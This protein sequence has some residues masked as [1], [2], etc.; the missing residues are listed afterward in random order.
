MSAGDDRVRVERDGAIATIVLNRPEKLNALTRDMWGMLGTAV[1]A[2]SADEAV[3]CIIV[4]GA[5]ERAFSPGNDIAEFATQRANKS[6]A[7]EY[8]EV[9]HRTADSLARCRH[10][11]V[12]QI[13]G[14]CVG[15]GLEIAASAGRRA[16]S[17]RRSRT[18]AW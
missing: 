10:P 3:R 9:M 8:G 11:V 17:A 15:G 13:H 7:I 5:G 12:A 1:D 2:L 6:Q 18:W 16:A 14:I 4:R